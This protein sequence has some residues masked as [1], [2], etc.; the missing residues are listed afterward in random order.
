MPTTGMEWFGV[1]VLMALLMVHVLQ[2]G[3]LGTSITRLEM[4]LKNL[5]A[6]YRVRKGKASE[7]PDLEPYTV[8]LDEIGELLPRDTHD[9]VSAQVFR[10]LRFRHA[11]LRQLETLTRGYLV[12]ED[13]T[14]A[15]VPNAVTPE[16]EPKP[17]AS[18]HLLPGQ[19]AYHLAVT[20]LFV[21]KALVHLE[22][23][24]DSYRATGKFVEALAF[25]AVLAGAAIA[26]FQLLKGD[27][28]PSS[29]LQLTSAFSRAFTAYGM[30]VLLSVGLW[31]YGRAT[32][33]QAERLLER[34]H[35]LRQGR[36]F[37]HL[38]NGRLSI[39]EMEKAFNW[40]VSQSNA[41]GDL[42]TDAQAPWG[43]VVKE[44]AARIPDLLKAGIQSTSRKDSAD[45]SSAKGKP[46]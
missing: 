25:V 5:Q 39:E 23:Q 42:Q 8:A 11:Q 38:N 12:H 22:Q 35:A 14:T 20:D 21:E 27:P 10:R 36:L 17:Q 9:E 1:S 2:K 37:V 30:I 4:M 28:A 33:D 44:F 13:L 18:A 19:R 24:A 3:Y 41:F 29:W 40:N 43:V 46:A 26:C 7:S 45:D 34:R 6:G 32:L 16:S 31:R 15:Q